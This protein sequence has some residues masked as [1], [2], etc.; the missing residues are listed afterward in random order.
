MKLPSLL[1]CTTGRQGVPQLDVP[2]SLGLPLP[3]RARFHIN[4]FFDERVTEP[5]KLCNEVS[6]C[7]APP[8]HQASM[9]D[10]FSMYHYKAPREYISNA[11]AMNLGKYSP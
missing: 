11:H 8:S 1:T 7:S 9:T 4:P 2:G 10:M 6:K 3:S 5:M